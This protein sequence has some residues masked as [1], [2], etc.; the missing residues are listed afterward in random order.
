MP[1][2]LTRCQIGG[3]FVD[4]AREEADTEGRTGMQMSKSATFLHPALRQ[5][6]F[7]KS[8][9]QQ[10]HTCPYMLPALREEAS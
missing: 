1:Q 8:G 7:D 3:G 4:G 5:T 10:A 6:F 9:Q 2:V